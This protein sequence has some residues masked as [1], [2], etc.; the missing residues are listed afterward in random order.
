M[1]VAI[2]GAVAATEAQPGGTL[3]AEGQV[4][5]SV[6]KGDTRTLGDWDITSFGVY[7]AYRHPLTDYFYLKGKLG[8][9][10]YDI[11]TDFA[12]APGSSIDTG[13]ETALSAGIGAGWKIGPGHVEVEV[14][15]HQGDVL[16]VSGGFHINF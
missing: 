7:A 8:I 15:T 9:V 6:V 10:S 16:F 1:S 3:A 2:S 14:T 11:N 13:R 5:L 4:T 12:P